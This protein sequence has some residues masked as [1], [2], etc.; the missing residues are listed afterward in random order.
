MSPCLA[1]YITLKSERNMFLILILS[2]IFVVTCSFRGMGLSL[3][4]M[5]SLDQWR[6][7]MVP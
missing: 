7:N 2:P 5:F 1:M 6:V 4:L 3:Y